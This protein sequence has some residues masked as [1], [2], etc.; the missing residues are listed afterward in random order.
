MDNTQIHYRGRDYSHLST[1]EGPY[2]PIE[3]HK[4]YQDDDHHTLTK[5][6]YIYIILVFVLCFICV[7][8]QVRKCCEYRR[9]NGEVDSVLVQ[10]ESSQRLLDVRANTGR[11]WT[12]LPLS[13]SK[14]SSDTS[15]KTAKSMFSTILPL[16]RSKPSSGTS[17][18]PQNRC[19]RRFCHF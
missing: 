1:K 17:L 12:I 4:W 19:F 14:P 18:K 2:R 7:I 15:P 3:H 16:S 10:S 11:F 8:P 6:G 5:E 13:R 9:E